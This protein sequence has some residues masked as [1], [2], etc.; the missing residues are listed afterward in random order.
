MADE[1][2]E[3][4]RRVKAGQTGA[5]SV[6][7]E[8]YHRPLLDFIHRLTPD[9]STV[10]DLGQEVFLSAY[11]SLE[12]FD[13]TRGTPFAAWLFIIARNHCYGELRRHRRQGALRSTPLDAVPPPVAPEPSPEEALLKEERRRALRRSVEQLPEPF[14]S[15]LLESLEDVPLHLAARRA[16]VP[17]GTAKSRLFRARVRLSA[18]VRSIFGET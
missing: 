7:V 18:V 11:R 3:V 1:D 2:L 5:F 10:E 8:R 6:L 4:I 15:A 9:P 13:E 16:G 12:R 14:R 17:P